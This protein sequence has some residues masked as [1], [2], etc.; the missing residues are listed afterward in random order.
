MTN[1]KLQNKKANLLFNK[2]K[3]SAV[4]ADTKAKPAYLNQRSLLTHFIFGPYVLLPIISSLV[5]LGGLLALIGLWTSQGKP[6]YRGDEAS[7]VFVSD[8]GAANH[9]LFICITVLTAVF[10]VLSLWAERWLR[11]MDRLPEDVRKR[12]R[13]L[14]WLAIFFGTIGGIA[15]IMLGVFD[16]FD[17]ST[18]HWS[19]TVIF[20]VGVAIS[21]IFQSAE[22]FA[23]KKDHPDR[24][25][26][27]RSAFIKVFVATTA[28]AAAITFA[29]L[30]GA[31]K[32]DAD[33]P[34]CNNI[35]SGAAGVEWGLAFWLTFYI[36]SLVLDLWPAGKTSPRYLRRLAKWQEQNE[37]HN[38]EHD[39]TGRNA[40][41]AYPERWQ[42]ADG[43]ALPEN[44]PVD[45]G[46]V[47]YPVPAGS[48]PAHGYSNSTEPL[49]LSATPHNFEGAGY[50]ES[51]DRSARPSTTYGSDT[52]LVGGRQYA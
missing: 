41:A 1:E 36:L 13:V 20:I 45:S 23:L 29:G 3:R 17:Y 19:M 18:V 32:G 34:R 21:A 46:V 38:L 26:L 16:T 2:E 51:Y 4:I 15:L 50:R 6:K 39:F 9:T 47:A 48:P 10:Y 27:R 35:T 8:V 37:P 25:H 14:D 33:T 22:I 42:G 49:P 11:H 43:Q 44:A 24:Q 30:Y 7:V 31:C 28:I 12:E 40:F 5:W 52:G